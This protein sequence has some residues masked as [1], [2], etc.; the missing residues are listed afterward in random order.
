MGLRARASRGSDEA[1]VLLSA[2][3]RVGS[4]AWL[5]LAASLGRAYRQLGLATY[6]LYEWVEPDD[7]CAD[8]DD[9]ED[10]GDGQFE[11]AVR[12]RR[13]MIT[14]YIVACHV[15]RSAADHL[16]L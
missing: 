16:R 9:Y 11:K 4:N 2:R 7:A 10:P 8:I 1:V 13:L 5:Q 12:E 14:T 3:Q 6:C 15:A